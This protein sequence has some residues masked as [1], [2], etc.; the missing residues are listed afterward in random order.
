MTDLDQDTG[1]TDPSEIRPWKSVAIGEWICTKNPWQP[2]DTLVGLVGHNGL[3]QVLHTKAAGGMVI[4]DENC[5]V[6]TAH[7]QELPDRSARA[8]IEKRW[9]RP[10]SLLWKHIAIGNWLYV[11]DGEGSRI[12]RYVGVVTPEGNSKALF[13]TMFNG[14]SLMAS[15]YDLVKSFGRLKPV[16]FA[17]HSELPEPSERHFLEKIVRASKTKSQSQVRTT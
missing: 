6:W 1:V 4:L 5:P 3:Q 9:R 17:L 15:P 8:Q 13:V 16:R 10:T 2:G 12:E 7:K 14:K 11:E